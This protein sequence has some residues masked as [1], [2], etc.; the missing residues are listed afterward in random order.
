MGQIWRIFNVD[1]RAIYVGTGLYR[2]LGEWFF[3][4]HHDLMAS[5]RIPCLPAEIDE[6]L[7][8]EERMPVHQRSTLLKL[9]NELLFMIFAELDDATLACLA[10]T[11]KD[12]LTIAKPEFLRRIRRWHRSW[13]HCRI[14]T[15]GEYT[16]S[17]DLNALPEGLLSE[18][19]KAAVN[20]YADE[21]A[22]KNPED[23]K[24]ARNLYSYASEHYELD[25]CSSYGMRSY[26]EDYDYRLPRRLTGSDK[27]MYGVL[28][29][30]I[31]SFTYP[32][33]AEVL[34]NIS[35]GEYV[36]DAGLTVPYRIT[37]A[38]A[39]VSQTCWSSQP[40][41]AMCCSQEYEEKLMRGRWAGDKFCIVT[42]DT[43]PKLE[44]GEWKDVTKEVDSLLRHICDQSGD[45][46]VGED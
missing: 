5:L 17:E 41:F 43:M 11:C 22:I 24:Y 25:E 8:S 18:D 37:L 26:D 2:K 35:K 45:L 40:S 15:L 14:I 10:I 38:H 13:A 4:S 16:C 12:F 20:A 46:V 34:C 39:L 30:P 21:M 19:E 6:W 3:R 9:S 7:K 32:K 29:G 28:A 36:R 27:V 23:A 33:G 44:D 1:H 42:E 31:F